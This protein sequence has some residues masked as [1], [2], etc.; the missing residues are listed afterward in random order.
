MEEKKKIKFKTIFNIIF[1]AVVLIVGYNIYKKYNFN[2]FTKAE[3]TL[4]IAKFERDSNVKISDSD[5][6]KIIND[7]YNDAMFFETVDVVPNTSYKVTCK[8]KTENVQSKNENTDSGAHICIADTIEKS[9]NVTGTTDWTDV[10]FYFN[11]KN[12]TQVDVGF[13]LGGFEDD[14]KR[15]S[16]VFRF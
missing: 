11:S 4:G 5:S 7:E 2:N 14:C 1:I 8:I 9:D 16:L 12:K 6:Y 3:H 10:T 15:N 13:R